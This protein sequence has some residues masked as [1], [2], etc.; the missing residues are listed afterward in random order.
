MS[1]GYL[2]KKKIANNRRKKGISPVVATVIL[3]AVAVVIAAALAGFAGSLFGSYS[4]GPQIKVRSL[5][6]DSATGD[7]VLTVSNAGNQGD[8]V[9]NISLGGTNDVPGGAVTITAGEEVI[10]ANVDGQDVTFNTTVALTQGQ[11]VSVVV[12]MQSGAQITQTI[13]VS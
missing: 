6:I 3:V 7:G 1:T 8:T 13:T 9:K 12:T 5:T 2:T 4:N 11:Q 10:P